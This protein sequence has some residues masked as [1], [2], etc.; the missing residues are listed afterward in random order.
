M[1]GSTGRVGIFIDAEN[2]PT[3]VAGRVMEIAAGFGRIVERRVY[4]DF[5]R[6]HLK[7]WAEAA[8]HHALSI[9]TAQAT[10]SGK[11][12]SDI[13]LAIDVAELMC[14]SDIDVFC[15]VTC[16]SDFIHL[17]TRLR[18]RGHRAIGIGG[19]KASPALRLAFDKFFEVEL[20]LKEADPPKAVKSTT[21]AKTA[22]A[23]EPAK[24]AKTAEN[25]KPAKPLETGKVVALKRAGDIRPYIVQALN[26]IGRAPQDWVEVGRLSS[27]IR[28]LNPE[29]K[30]NNFGSAKFSTVLKNCEFLETRK[31]GTIGMQVRVK[32]ITAP[33]VQGGAGA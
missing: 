33:L 30:P 6:E 29:F 28:Q 23:E 7:P 26:S 4:G 17:A 21:R 11:N 9:Q 25:T 3:R 16:D 8:T 22:K 27:A 13:M 12:S 10:I 32:D 31:D 14:R 20:A 18:M 1:A 15:I 2:L 5:T 19:T 24:V